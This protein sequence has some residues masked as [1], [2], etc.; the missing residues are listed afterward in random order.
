MALWNEASPVIPMGPIDD[1]QDLQY[2]RKRKPAPTGAVITL[3]DSIAAGAS[4]ASPATTRFG[5]LFANGI[6]GGAETNMAISGSCCGRWIGDQLANRVM[7]PGDRVLILPGFNDARFGGIVGANLSQYSANLRGTICYAG[8]PEVNKIF[9]Q[10]NSTTLNPAVTF[11][12]AWTTSVTWLG[13]AAQSKCGA[14]STTP[15]DF[16]QVTV[17]GN[18]IHIMLGGYFSFPAAGSITVDGVSYGAGAFSAQPLMDIPDGLGGT[19]WQPC[20]ITIPVGGAGNAQ[21]VVRITNT[22]ASNLLIPYIA[23]FDISSS[24]LPVVYVGVAPRMT[25]VGYAVAPAN[26]NDVVIRLYQAETRRVVEACAAE[27]LLV[28]LVDED[29]SW[30]PH[31]TLTDGAQVHPLELAHKLWAQRMLYEESR[32]SLT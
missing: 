4:L 30:L 27:G 24:Q 19:V 9:S 18:V 21:H 13:L 5:R 6:V 1:R 17:T 10:S 28:R 8:V 26:G 31:A 2:G 20:C 3:G 23:G 14:Y 15:G 12:G 29:A 11:G 22:T 32:P 16:M 25:A 7:L